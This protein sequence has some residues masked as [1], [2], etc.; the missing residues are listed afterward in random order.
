MNF[1]KDIGNL[2]EDIFVENYVVEEGSHGDTKAIL[3]LLKSATKRGLVSVEDTKKGYMVKSLVDDSQYLT[4]R[5]EK[6]YH[7]LRRY[8]QKLERATA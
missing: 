1:K 5:G 7:D 6:G 2:Y 3:K 4:H 8:L